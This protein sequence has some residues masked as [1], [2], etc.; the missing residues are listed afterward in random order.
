MSLRDKLGQ[1]ATTLSMVGGVDSMASASYNKLRAE[2]HKALLDRV[3]LEVM[4]KMSSERLKEELRM[5]IDVLLAEAGA[6]LN[7]QERRQMVADIQNEVMGHGPIEPLLNDPTVSDILINGSQSIFVER[8]GR[9]EPTDLKFDDDAHLMRIIDKIVSRVGRRIDESSPMVDARLPDGSR[10]NAIIPPLAIDGPSMSIRR[11]AVIPLKMDDLIARQSVP[12]VFAELLSAMVKAKLNILISGGTGS[13]KTT[14]LNVLSGFIPEQER[15][16]TIEDAAELQLQQAHV[17]RLE[18]RPANIEG[19][20]EI[21]QRA[22]VRNSL[23]MRPDRIVLGEVRAGEAFDMLQA[24]NTGHEGSMATVHANT[25]RDALSRL[26]NMLGM[27]GLNLPPKAMRQQIASAITAVVQLS[28]LTDGQR[29][30]VSI[31]EITGMEGDIVTMQ[32]IFSFQQTGVGERG[33]VMGHFKA[34][35][36]RPQFME[37]V[38]SFGIKLPEQMFDPSKS[39]KL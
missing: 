14:M 24:M 9:I 7:S 11:F 21:S 16:I 15:I 5:V 18:T 29:K 32:E 17:I 30:L 27:A 2:T 3:D 20:G 25:P 19:K 6:A 13:G 31:S 26:E 38:R 36:V 33:E 23:R 1:Q 35:G 12:A 39:H 10:V 28:R 37:R 4:S 8:A 34:S 22:L